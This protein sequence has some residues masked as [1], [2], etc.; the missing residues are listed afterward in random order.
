MLHY[1]TEEFGNAWSTSHSYGSTVGLAVKEA[2]RNV[3]DLI[4]CSPGSLVFTGS[5]TEANSLALMGVM[6]TAPPGSR[7]LIS[8]AEHSSVIRCANQLSR[9][10]HHLTVI[11]VDEFCV[12]DPQHI[13]NSIDENTV[14]V[15][16]IFANNEVGSLNPIHEIGKLCSD[17]KVLFHTDANRPW[18]RFRSISLAFEPTS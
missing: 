1:L 7:F 5:A 10:D 6:K 18:V 2:H 9:E 16:V 11:P 12:V 14:L 15:S 17:A 13:A 4:G 3:G 8:A